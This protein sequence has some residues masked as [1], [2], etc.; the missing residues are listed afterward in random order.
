MISFPLIY[1]AIFFAKF[2]AGVGHGLAYV[3]AVQQIGEI[4]VDTMRGRFGTSLHLF[5][6]K[7]G[8]M[9]GSLVIKFF[10]I[11][12]R[13]DPNRFLGIIS[14]CL[15]ALSIMT[16]LIFYEESI[17]TLIEHGQD[18]DALKILMLVHGETEETP[19][20]IKHFNE[21]KMM[22][23]DDKNSKSGI[24]KDGNLRPLIIVIMLRV[25]FV[26]TFN[27]ALKHIHSYVNVTKNSEIDYTFILNFVHAFTTFVVVFTIDS[28]RRKHVLIAT[29]G[30]SA[31][32]LIFGSLKASMYANSLWFIFIIFVL[33]EFFSAIGLGLTAHIYSSE[34][35]ATAKKTQSIAFTSIIEFLMQ[36]LF[37]VWTDNQI[38]FHSFDA[39]ILLTSGFFLT[40][41]TFYLFF[42]LPET[43]NVSIRK[44]R[45]KF[46]E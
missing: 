25:A 16:T 18:S 43:K 40:L 14:L 36:I 29:I 31:T 13:M 37:I 9:S 42:N 46:L 3:I 10:T 6:L 20:V 11:K 38:Y 5:L 28:G 41:L 30:T 45:S 26:L 12:D 44:T 7:G 33:F 23:A 19:E 39:T 17:L 27:Y 34:A 32:M 24:F 8:I 1:N 2:I 15:S 35:F 22:I 21:F 4:C